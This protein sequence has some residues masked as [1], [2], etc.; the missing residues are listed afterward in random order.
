MRRRPGVPAVR[1][2]WSKSSYSDSEGGNCLESPSGANGRPSAPPLGP[3]ASPQV[4]PELKPRDPSSSH[5]FPSLWERL[6]NQ[7]NQPS[8]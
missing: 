2:R 6:K 8:S 3:P 4:S 7:P 1:S 5:G